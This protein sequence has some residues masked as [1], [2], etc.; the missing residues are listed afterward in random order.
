M[1]ELI[2]VLLLQILATASLAQHAPGLPVRDCLPPD[3]PF[4]PGEDAE[5]QRYAALIAADFERYFSAISDY[6]ACLDAS[7]Q[8]AFLRAQQISAQHRSF[9]DR[10]DQLG[11]TGEGALIHP[12]L[13]RKENP[14]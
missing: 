12:P 6:L 9:R 11:L 3:E 10:L 5:L 4:V 2:L 13:S 14:Q 8:A 7:R 1:R